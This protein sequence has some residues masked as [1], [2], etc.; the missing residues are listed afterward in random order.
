MGY[1]LDKIRIPKCVVIRTIPDIHHNRR[2]LL[3]IFN[4]DLMFGTYIVQR[5]KAVFPYKILNPTLTLVVT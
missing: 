5:S 1:V 4:A 3:F 2:C